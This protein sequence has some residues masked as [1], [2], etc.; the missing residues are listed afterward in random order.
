[1]E[2]I[3]ENLKKA[4]QKDKDFL[5]KKRK[6][7]KFAETNKILLNKRSNS[8]TILTNKKNDYRDRYSL[9]KINLD[10]YDNDEDIINNPKETK[11]QNNLI[12]K[13]SENK[14][15]EDI[16]DNSKLKKQ[17][18]KVK[19]LTSFKLLIQIKSKYNY[20]KDNFEVL[21]FCGKGAYGTVLQ[22]KLKSDSPNIQNKQN[23]I[24]NKKKEEEKIY[25]IKVVD[26]ESIREVNK[27][28][29]IYL[30]SQIL[31]E[32]DNPLIVKIYDTFVSE[33][34]V[35]M[36][37]DYLSNGDFATFLKMNYPLKEDMI[38]FYAAE[39]VLFLEYLQSKNI[40]HRDLKPEN[41]ML[42]DR[43]HIQIIDFATV[44]KIG[45]YYDKTEMKF[46]KDNFDL[47]NN[48]DD[49]KGRKLIVN[50]DEDDDDENEEDEEIEDNILNDNK[51][52]DDIFNE[53][54]KKRKK[55][56]PIR[57]RTFVGTSEYVSPEVLDDQSAEYGSDLWAFGIILY[58]MFC[59]CT[60]FKGKTQYLT[61]QNIE[62]LEI[63]YPDKVSI[64]SNAKN[65]ISQILIKDPKK[66]LGAG[67]P[68]SVLDMEHL[69][70]HPFFKGIKWKNIYS[71]NVP[72]EKKFKFKVKKLIK[73][74]N[75][76]VKDNKICS[77]VEENIKIIKKGI[78]SK[79]SFWFHYVER[80]VILDSSPKITIKET[81]KDV[82]KGIIC[83]NKK[84]KVYSSSS[85]IFC[86]QT[87]QDVYKFKSKLNDMVDWISAIK[88]CINIYGKDA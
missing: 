43:Y 54:Y 60:P 40:V 6:T 80:L 42:N 17:P 86:V 48:I 45:Y 29:Q 77:H 85:E 87:P 74:T 75:E 9:N 82:V 59:G 20:T 53:G 18:K 16:S 41:I 28:Y 65:L 51:I 7:F 32:L 24:K 78:L 62:K 33:G 64:S 44:R 1:M 67:P 70:K 63:T 12:I 35:H 13:N 21:S 5:I 19:S 58:Q 84:C 11:L 61:F 72:N 66:R 22:V 26:I 83:L 31:S 76:D 3:I 38:K 88:Q 69:K 68:K 56:T 14:D 2:S 36:V 71:Q 23:I 30:E 79:K 34:K 47:E 55:N 4:K 52:D 50:P 46:K 8:L 27:L 39:M 49:I 15:N 25:A 37:M 10:Y 81:E 57:N 73:K